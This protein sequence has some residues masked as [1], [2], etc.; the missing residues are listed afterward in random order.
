MND[1]LIHEIVVRFR[2]GARYDGSPRACTSAAARSSEYWIRSTRSA[3]LIRPP[4]HPGPGHDEAA[5]STSIRGRSPTLARYPDITTQRI[6]EELHRLGIPGELFAAVPA[7]ARTASPA[8][9][10]A[11]AAVRD[12]AGRTGPDGL[13]HIRHRLHD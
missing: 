11:R 9:C 6:H 4:D 1:A 7:G 3:V 5:S 2:G 10:F 13:L 12:R 8:G